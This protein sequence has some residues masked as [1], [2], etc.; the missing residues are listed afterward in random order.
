MKYKR[1]RSFPSAIAMRKFL[2]AINKQIQSK[3]IEGTSGE[4]NE[5]EGG[6][7]NTKWTDK[8]MAIATVALTVG[9]LALFWQAFQ[10]TKAVKDQFAIANTPYLQFDYV[11]D[12]IV[13]G[14]HPTTMYQLSNLSKVPCKIQWIQMEDTLDVHVSGL[15]FG[16]PMQISPYGSTFLQPAAPQ[17]KINRYSTD[18]S[19]YRAIYTSRWKIDISGVDSL[20]RMGSVSHFVYGTVYYVNQMDNKAYVYQFT[21]RIPHDVAGRLDMLVNV[22]APAK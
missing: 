4:E 10:Q 21:A 16:Q 20:V 9:T 17:L 19:P 15:V 8:T 12:S 11:Y 14:K 2:L 1:L 5:R 18:N 7:S 22:N 6:E 3:S 13:P